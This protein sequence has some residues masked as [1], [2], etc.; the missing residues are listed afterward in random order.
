MLDP[1]LLPLSEWGNFYVIAGSA[2]AGLM[3]LMFVVIALGRNP[4]TAEAQGGVRAFGTPTVLHFCGVLLVAATLSIPR[5]TATSL[6]LCIGATGVGG[7]GLS[8]WVVVQA[9]RQVH[10]SPLV[11]D[12]LWHVA[13]PFVAYAALTVGALMVR[14]W[15]SLALDTVAAASLLLLFIGVHNAWDSAVW[16]A[17]RDGGSQ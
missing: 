9:R 15:P 11:S 1:A 3:G 8:G 2:A 16:I 13:A 5:H 10:Y 12:W 17:T 14:P 4:I 6:A 7:L